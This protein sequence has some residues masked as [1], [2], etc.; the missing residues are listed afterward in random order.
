MKRLLLLNILLGV[1][2]LQTHSQVSSQM[3]IDS[4]L[5]TNAI[6]TFQKPLS[7]SKSIEYKSNLN[8]FL[9]YSNNPFSNL[10]AEEIT[11]RQKSDRTVEK[12]RPNNSMPCVNPRGS[13]P[14]L[15]CEPDSSIR[16]SLLIKEIKEDT[17]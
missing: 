13:F 14:M 12:L 11:S 7:L 5:K 16:Y 6:N 10:S 8:D 2:L 17:P 9:K 15:I 1:F 4:T 3:D